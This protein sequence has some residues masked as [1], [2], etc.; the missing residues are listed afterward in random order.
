MHF[1]SMTYFWLLVS[2]LLLAL[3][4]FWRRH[5]KCVKVPAIFLWD[6]KEEQPN[7]GKSLRITRLP[8]SFYLEALAILLLAAAAAMPF[9][10]RKSEFPP[11]AV[12]LDNS[13]SMLSVNH[14]SLSFK[15][16][17]IKDLERE[18]SRFP[19]RKV[20]WV[21]AG[22]APQKLDSEQSD[23]LG[24]WTCNAIT[25]DIPS[26]LQMARQMCPGGDIL[27]LSD[28]KPTDKGIR[29]VRWISHGK[30]LANVGFVN[31]RRSGASV[32]LEIYNASTSEAKVTLSETDNGSGISTHSSRNIILQPNEIKKTEW[33]LDNPD[34]IAKF[35]ISTGSNT[36]SDAIA[37]DNTALLLP[38]SRPPLAYRLAE[39]LSETQEALLRRT[40]MRNTEYVSVGEKEL[41]ICGANAQAGNFHR[42]LWHGEG[43]A[44]SSAPITVRPDY[45]RLLHGLSFAD[46]L[47]PAEAS[48]DLPGTVLLYQGDVKLLSIEQ[49][50]AFMDIHLNL[51]ESAGNLAKQALWPSFF[52]NLSDYLRSLRHAPDRVNV[53]CGDMVTV[54]NPMRSRIAA[55]GVE[56]KSNYPQA[57]V[58]FDEPG[59]HTINEWQVAVNPFDKSESDLS[60]ASSCDISPE[61]SSG[62]LA[63][64]V[65]RQIAF[66][67]MLAALI[68]LAVHWQLALRRR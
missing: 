12:V 18:L 19:G 35:V 22:S 58:I 68:V 62:T 33:K 20:H 61:V 27:V 65:R 28:H 32:L 64:S 51:H 31:A 23:V 47:W 46:L 37:I 15:E 24:Q 38:E 44:V 57:Y 4:Y 59:L 48:L 60:L 5:S 50:G 34:K 14:N 56:V 10:L 45:Q 21:L 42:L 6:V 13:F 2:V 11:L 1:L 40:L 54:P 53:R 7:A 52:W 29:D 17:C 63:H 3:L 43:R 26:A 41:V 66:A 8:L 55:D 39:G 9:I 49:R 16:L 36:K 30:P 25:A 67:F